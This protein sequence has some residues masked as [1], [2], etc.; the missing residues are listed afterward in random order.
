[1]KQKCLLFIALVCSS[2]L[3]SQSFTSNGLNYDVLDATAK[4]ARLIASPNASGNVVVPNLVDYN[5]DVL[6]VTQIGSGAFANRTGLLTVYIPSSVGFIG[7]NVFNGCTALNT[8]IVNR[9]VP[10]VISA[11]TFAGVNL[12]L[13]FLE[14]PLETLDTY[15]NS[16]NWGGFFGYFAC[17]PLINA[18]DSSGAFNN[19]GIICRGDSI[20]LTAPI[21][22]SYQWNVGNATTQSITVSPQSTTTY[23]VI[24]FNGSCSGN[25]TVGVIPANTITRSSTVGTINQVACINAPISNIMYNTTG[26][27]GATFAGL[28]AGVTGTWNSNAVTISGTPTVTGTFNYS[29]TSTGGCGT[30]SATGTIIVANPNVVPTFTQVAPI[31]SGATLPPL[32]I[33]SNNNISGSWSP[34]LSNTVTLTY[35]FTPT[36]GL[37]ATTTT[38]T[39]V[40]HPNPTAVTISGGNVSVCQNSIVT[41]TANGGSP[42]DTIIWQKA[43]GTGVG[44]SFVT[45]GGTTANQLVT[46]SGVYRVITTNGFNCSTTSANVSVTMSDYLFSGSIATSDAT[47]TGR[48]TRD[49]TAS[50]CAAAK[51]FPG[52]FTASGIRF[53]DSYTITNPKNTPVCATIGY[54]AP[55]GISLFS[56]AYLNSFNPSATGTNYL[57]DGGSSYTQN[58]T[59]A[60]YYQATIPANGT[61]VVVLHATDAGSVCANYELSVELPRDTAGVTVTPNTAVCVGVPVALQAS[62]ADSYLW[63]NSATSTTSSINATPTATT[64]YNVTLGYGNRSC[65][66]TAS[67][68]VVVSPNVTPTFTQVAPICAEATLNAL[69][70]TSNNGIGGSWSPTINNTQT[71]TYTFT[72]TTA[73]C[74]NTATMTIDVN[75]NV[76]PT[77]TQVAP[78]CAGATLSALPTTSN[79]NIT[80]TWSPVIDNLVTKTYTFT[81]TMGLC[82]VTTTMTIVVNPL[83]IVSAGSA[84]TAVCLGNNVSL[85]GTINRFGFAGDFAPSNWDFMHDNVNAISNPIVNTS[86]APSS[87][88]IETGIPIDNSRLVINSYSTIILANGTITFSWNYISPDFPQYNIPRVLHNGVSTILNGFIFPGGFEPQS[89]TM[90]ISVVAGQRF[91]FSI[92]EYPGRQGSAKVKISNFVFTPTA[93]VNWTTTN[94]TLVGATNSLSATATT[95]GT[96]TITATNSNGC[97]ASSN[98]M[99]T[100]N[101][102]PAAPTSVAQAFC[103]SRTVANL[104]PVPSAT[105]KWYSNL[106]GGSVLANTT[107]LTTGSYFVSETS[108]AG[109]E[110]P[111]T[112]VAVTINPIPNA[113]TSVAQAFCGSRTVADLTPAPSA[114]IKW[115]SNL[116]GGSALANTTSLTTANYYVSETNAAGCESPR[117]TVAVT[118]NPIPNAPTSAAQAFCGS[119][120]LTDLTPAPSATIKWYSNLTGGSALANTTSLTTA[121]YYVSE[122][123]AAGCESPRTTVAVTINPIPNAPTSVAQA[124]CGSRTLTDLTPAPSATIKWYSNIIGG[125]ALANTTS[126]TTANY[127]V[128]ETSAAG[129]ESPRITVAITINPIPNALAAASSQT[130][131]SGASVSNLAVT[132]IGIR[133]YSAAIGGTLL[134]SNTNLVDN[135]NYFAS[136]TNVQGCEST[137][138]TQVTA[139]VSN[140]SHSASST[141]VLC[142]GGNTGTATISVANGISP[143]TYLW[144]NGQTNSIATGL[145][146]GIYTYTITDAIGCTRTG[147]ATVVQPTVLAITTSS[148]P[149]YSYNVAYSTTLA[150]NGGIAPYIF[151]VSSGT[152]PAGFSLSATGVLSGTSLTIPTSTFTAQITD[153]NGCVATRTYT[154]RI[155][156]I[157]ITVTA[158]ALQKV[159]G[160]ADPVLTYTVVPALQS[161]TSFTGSLVRAAG[162]N[163]GTYAISQGSLSAGQLYVITYVEANFT[164]IKANQT[165]T[166]NQTLAIGCD[167][168]NSINLIASASSGLPVF[169]TSSNLAVVTINNST[170]SLV[171]FGQAN[172]IASQAGNNNYN[173]AVSVPNPILISQPG[174]IRKKFADVIFF[175]NTSSHFVSYKWFKNGV[176]VV[177]QTEQYYHDTALLNGTYFAKVINKNGVE[178][179]TC[180]ITFSPPA[181]ATFIKII[182]NPASAGSNYELQTNITSTN[183]VGSQLRVFDVTGNLIESRSITA[184][185]TSMT[186]PFASGV[187]ILRLQLTNGEVQTCNLLV[188]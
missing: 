141:A 58:T 138:R 159:Y 47:Q 125:L 70:T 30:A 149:N 147:A 121:N 180:T 17:R 151:T 182:P 62:L 122:T 97:T 171:N 124:F 38:M 66:A 52:V 60:V 23:Q 5:N 154:I 79:N 3:Y 172:I 44:D 117:T 75:L 102:I 142:N 68:E 148:I 27:N 167:G 34:P 133:W 93:A 86:L 168:I 41:L 18:A 6:T 63:N 43:I 49:G 183:L 111:R 61:I 95:P 22:S 165:I 132:G 119:R 20:T 145:L 56:A 127:Y 169:F 188:K 14:I 46:T 36:A 156:T 69:P 107:S 1:M 80:G 109:C 161:G 21:S 106:T 9:A 10:P 157:P 137:T 128:S 35:T 140:M 24:T 146:A 178:I 48:I 155:N 96:Y 131:C 54:A 74:N 143:Y 19:D 77:F 134:T 185:S 176:Q 51:N 39:V 181:E 59:S 100:F 120:T 45:F 139:R 104:T 135:T 94:G 31:C 32:P 184:A 173:T 186:A 53:Y 150:A 166:F 13:I 72:P 15:T 91:N 78:I 33:I 84:P 71:T 26:A 152:L 113:P 177:G 8:I 73:L 37:C 90:S 162:E 16:P 126:L 153:A 55:C 92:M 29:V 114:T 82:A 123:N 108:A 103:G 42:T 25:I 174:L 98:V 163:V 11:N 4:T 67:A 170:A 118:I 40:V 136:Q 87:I 2:M 83:P 89:G 158:N 175:D 116:T 179:T 81:P 115:Y 99:V 112:T 7:D 64:T 57:A 76:V 65:T 12:R 101:P 110:S 88:E 28:P 164:I 50:T 187:Y 129:C 130:F 85:T 105:I 144:S 160:T